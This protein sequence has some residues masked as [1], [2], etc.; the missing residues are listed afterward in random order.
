M[1]KIAITCI[2]SILYSLNYFCNAAHNN[3]DLTADESSDLIAAFLPRTD[4]KVDASMLPPKISNE[5]TNTMYQN[6]PNKSQLEFST[7]FEA[8]FKNFG[9]RAYKHARKHYV[10]FI[11]F[12]IQ[13][14]GKCFWRPLFNPVRFQFRSRPKFQCRVKLR[15]K[16]C[17]QTTLLHN[18]SPQADLFHP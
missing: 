12:S 17:R 9:G 3:R 15:H 18:H 1:K 4:M 7:E 5:A 13:Q 8:L 14:V 11:Y 2:L 16:S 10:L 6:S